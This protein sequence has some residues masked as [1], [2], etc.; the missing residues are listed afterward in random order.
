VKTLAHESIEIINTILRRINFRA[1]VFYRGQVCDSWF[2]D[3]SGSG[4]INFHVIC[5]GDCWLHLPG[6]Q[7]ATYLRGGD[8]VVFPEDAVHVLS[9]SKLPPKKFGIQEISAETQFSRENAGTALL[10]GYLITD[11]L[12]RKL[13]LHNLPS[14]VVISGNTPNTT[15]VSINSLLDL[16]FTEAKLNSLGTT[17]ILERLADALLF[18]V[19]R[20]IAQNQLEIPG[21]LGVLADSYL[22]KAVYAF[23]LEPANPWSLESLA[24]VACLSRS[25]FAERFFKA[26][27]IPPME[28]VAIWRMYL[29]RRWLEQENAN[30][31]DVAERCG[32]QSTAAFSK[33]FKRVIGVG[34]GQC[35][36]LSFQQRKMTG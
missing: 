19:V 14:F 17:A 34:P 7:E 28:F 29:A 11:Q 25:V 33:A 31:V 23:T 20:E 13:L 4:H 15:A 5:H 8:V 12:V 18:Y 36:K 32:Y 6:N 21:L 22:S 26:C 9:S 10:C 35:R 16:L 24:S 3:T 1:E 2:L 30:V 27:N